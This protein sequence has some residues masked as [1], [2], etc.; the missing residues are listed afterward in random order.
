MR[1]Y[2]PQFFLFQHFTRRDANRIAANEFTSQE[3]ADYNIQESPRSVLDSYSLRFKRGHI[4]FSH[5]SR[6]LLTVLYFSLPW[7]GTHITAPLGSANELHPWSEFCALEHLIL[8][9]E[10]SSS[11]LP[12]EWH[13]INTLSS[14]PLTIDELLETHCFEESIGVLYFFGDYLV[15]ID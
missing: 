4:P 5:N 9:W 14:T 1:T 7:N 6:F 3:C 13:P 2:R 11:G 10:C 8:V 15:G 12:N